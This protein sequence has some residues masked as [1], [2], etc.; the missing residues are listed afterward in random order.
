[1]QPNTRGRLS[2]HENFLKK[3]FFLLKISTYWPNTSCIIPD[4]LV[5]RRKNI[6]KNPNYTKDFDKKTI[7]S[8]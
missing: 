2:E 1:M 4:V 8:R 5:R 3:T 6:F 7:C